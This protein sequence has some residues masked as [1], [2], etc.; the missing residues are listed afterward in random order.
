MASF[1]LFAVGCGLIAVNYG[2]ITR[3]WILQQ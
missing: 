3:G 2:L 1:F